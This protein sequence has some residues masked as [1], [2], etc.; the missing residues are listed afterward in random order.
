MGRDSLIEVLAAC[1]AAPKKLQSNYVR[2]NAYAVARLASLN[3]L[4]T[5]IDDAFGDAWR[6]TAEGLALVEATREELP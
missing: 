5:R 2:D 3:L 4:T 6:V 1:Y